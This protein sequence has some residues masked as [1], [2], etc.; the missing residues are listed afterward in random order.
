[1]EIS[2]IHVIGL[3][4]EQVIDLLRHNPLFLD[5]PGGEKLLIVCDLD[6]ED[7]LR[8]LKESFGDSIEVKKRKLDG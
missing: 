3:N 7:I 8:M 6:K 4:T 1:M 2:E 5:G